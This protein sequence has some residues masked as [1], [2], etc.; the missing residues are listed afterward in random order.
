MSHHLG[1]TVSLHLVYFA[2]VLLVTR[3][4]ALATLWILRCRWLHLLRCLLTGIRARL[5]DYLILTTSRS[6]TLRW[7]IGTHVIFGVLIGKQRSACPGPSIG[8]RD[9][10]STGCLLNNIIFPWAGCLNTTLINFGETRT[11]W[12]N[13]PR[14]RSLLL[15]QI[16]LLYDFW[17]NFRQ[18]WD[19][20]FFWLNFLP[21]E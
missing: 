12:L 5:L 14:L 21:F 18:F 2:F 13:W 3:Y 11:L 1:F 4:F 9:A 8:L 16:N 19:R 15:A 17:R 6:P 7:S 10:T 20:R